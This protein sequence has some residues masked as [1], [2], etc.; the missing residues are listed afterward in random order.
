MNRLAAISDAPTASATRLQK[1]P[2]G[3]SARLKS[4]PWTS[5]SMFPNRGMATMRGKHARLAAVLGGTLVCGAVLSG[6]V[7]PVSQQ[8]FPVYQVVVDVDPVG[9]DVAVSDEQGRAVAGLTRDDFVV[10]EDGQP[11]E[12]RSAELVGMPYSI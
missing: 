3:S 2:M 1:L 12:L 8:A 5:G 11:Q 9:V 7:A 10:L 6:Q 4:A